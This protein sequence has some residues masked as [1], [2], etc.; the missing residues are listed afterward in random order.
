VNCRHTFHD[1]CIQPWLRERST[2][3]PVCRQ[4]ARGEDEQP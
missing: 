2:A 1:G 3:C 4:D